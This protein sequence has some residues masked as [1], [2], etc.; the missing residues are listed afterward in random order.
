MLSSPVLR[1]F[2]VTFASC[3][4]I[5]IIEIIFFY[6]RKSEI[7][8]ANNRVVCIWVRKWRNNSHIF[9]FEEKKINA[10]LLSFFLLFLL[11]LLSIL[12]K[13]FSTATYCERA[14]RI[15]SSWTS[16][17]FLF[18]QLKSGI[19]SFFKLSNAYC[20]L[21]V[22]KSFPCFWCITRCL[23]LKKKLKRLKCYI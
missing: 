22:T 16:Q 23:W 18:Y 21:R 20:E 1:C 13:F 11:F 14:F 2:F 9:I 7:N 15:L 3:V 8:K 19:N 5:I 4:H 17:I 6:E 10:V 12:L